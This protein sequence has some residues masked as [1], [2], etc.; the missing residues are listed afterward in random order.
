MVESIC[1]QIPYLHGSSSFQEFSICSYSVIC[2]PGRDIV[3]S[4]MCKINFLAGELS[5]SERMQVYT[6]ARELFLNRSACKQN[7]VKAR[8]VF[9]V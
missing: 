2:W 6:C 4:Y 9:L 3:C 1:K 5:L 8:G 7:F